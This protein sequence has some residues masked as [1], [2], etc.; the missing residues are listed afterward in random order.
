EPRWGRWGRAWSA[1]WVPFL[2]SSLVGG[3][4]PPRRAKLG[5]LRAFPA[6]D[7]RAATGYAS[8]RGGR[9]E[10]TRARCSALPEAQPVGELGPR[11]ARPPARLADRV[12]RAERPRGLPRQ[13]PRDPVD[14]R[15]QQH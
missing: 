9:M 13:P 14:Q 12:A 4:V 6:P 15:T 2:S 3:R 11:R 5:N 7:A 10:K 1:A 8:S